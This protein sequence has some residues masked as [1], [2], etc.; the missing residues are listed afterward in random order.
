[1]GMLRGWEEEEER[2][3]GANTYIPGIGRTRTQLAV[4]VPA[5]SAE[6][7]VKPLRMG[8]ASGGHQQRVESTKHSQHGGVSARHETD[9]PGPLVG[10]ATLLG[11]AEAGV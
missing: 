9:A 11:R 5:S 4:I 6:V 8:L 7:S 10:A 3:C 2:N 1:V